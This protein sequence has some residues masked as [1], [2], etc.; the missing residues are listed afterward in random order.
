MREPTVPILL[1]ACVVHVVR[2]DAVDFAVFFGTAVLIV[3]T[4]GRG[5][6]SRRGANPGAVRAARPVS[7]WVLVAGMTIFAVAAAL[8][9]PASLGARLV[10]VAVGLAALA[11]VL[12]HPRPPGAA[13]AVGSRRAGALPGWPVWAT[14]GVAACLWELTSFVAQ[15]VWPLDQNNHPAVSDLVGPLLRSW[16]GR[17]VF[18]LL[19]AGAGWW[20]LRR[21]VAEAPASP[22]GRSAMPSSSGREGAQPEAHAVEPP[23][24]ARS[25]PGSRHT[26]LQRRPDGHSEAG[27]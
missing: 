18:L 24:G 15:Q 8:P 23:T 5:V 20:L 7:V 3:A 13:A 2:R 19:W 16:P 4:A 14:I 12:F 27:R 9:A 25:E 1:A 21:F 26:R 6:G 10:M 11:V 22:A 17:V